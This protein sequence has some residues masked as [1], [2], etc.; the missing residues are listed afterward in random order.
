[1]MVKAVEEESP[2]AFDCLFRLEPGTL[3]FEEAINLVKESVGKA[4]IKVL[5]VNGADGRVTVRYRTKDIDAIGTRDYERKCRDDSSSMDLTVRHCFFSACD[6]ELVFEH[7]EVSKV[8]AI[9]IKDDLEAEKDESFAVELYN[10]TDG[11]QL[12]KHKKTV[13][14]IIN[15]DGK[16]SRGD[17]FTDNCKIES[18]R[19]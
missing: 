9:P 12:G 10:P 6:S 18:F 4:E 5:R 7:G 17:R 15:D 13:V 14:T 16:G 19:L 11:A 8:I 1:M 3:E 2:I